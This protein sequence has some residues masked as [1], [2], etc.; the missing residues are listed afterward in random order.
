MKVIHEPNDTYKVVIKAY[1]DEFVTLIM[2]LFNGY[3]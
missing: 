1:S 3:L 2:L